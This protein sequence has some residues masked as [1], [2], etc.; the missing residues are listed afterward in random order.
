MAD[1]APQRVPEFLVDRSLGRY[2]VPA[3]LRAQGQ[4]VHTLWSVYGAAEENLADTA[5]LRDAGR[6]GWA[7]LTGNPRIRWTAH[8]LAVVQVE[9]VQVFVLP[10]GQLR[11]AEQA[12]RFV[13]NLAAIHRACERPGPFIYVVLPDRI[14]RRWP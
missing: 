13:D 11:G 14:E 8:E 2:D 6:W 12:A 4:T 3:A 1:T 7:V 9:A 5:W 10:R